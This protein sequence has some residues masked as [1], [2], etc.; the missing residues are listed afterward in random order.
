MT[1]GSWAAR[2]QRRVMASAE[3]VWS[4][5]GDHFLLRVERRGGLYTARAHSLWNDAQATCANDAVAALRSLS[6]GLWPVSERDAE[7]A[8]AWARDIDARG[9]RL[10]DAESVRLRA[11]VKIR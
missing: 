9:L 11:E 5:S 4:R 6:R 3:V 2:L 10:R 1:P 8:L 7:A